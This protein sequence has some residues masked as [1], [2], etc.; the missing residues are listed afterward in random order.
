MDMD[1]FLQSLWGELPILGEWPSVLNG[2]RHETA[3]KLGRVRSDSG[4]VT[5]E[6]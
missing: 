1:D 6:A 2:F 3:V 4:W 5:L